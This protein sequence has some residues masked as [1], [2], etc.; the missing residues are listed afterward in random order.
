MGPKA[1]VWVHR[2]ARLRRSSTTASPIDPG[3]LKW[4]ETA[5]LGIGLAVA[6]RVGLGLVMGAAWIAVRS[7]I[8]AEQLPDLSIYGRLPMPGSPIG[9]SLLGV[10]PR[11]DAVQHLNLALRG[12]ADMG[13]GSTVFFPL[14]ALLT[15]AVAVVAGDTIV[16]GLIVSTIAAA[17]AFTFLILI[18]EHLF[19]RDSGKWAA[20]ALAA[21]PMAVF[22]MAP[23]TES[24]YLAL[25]LGAFLAAYRMRWFAAAGLGALASFTRGPGMAASAAFAVLA[26][27]Q[28][29]SRGRGRR[30]ASVPGVIAAVLAPLVAAGAFLAWRASAGF[31]P[32][33]VVLE[34]YVHTTLVDPLTGAYLALRQWLEIHDIPTTL[35]ILSAAGMVA[36]TTLMILRKRWRRPELLAYMLVN[37]VVLLGR[38]TEG[39][40]S[41]KSLSRY[42]LVLFPAFLVVGDWLATTRRWIR[43]GYVAVSSTLLLILSSLYVFW[44]FIG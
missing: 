24:L 14:Y 39:A 31:A 12:Y 33:P 9:Q 2:M 4:R 28:W 6:L 34:L 1:P 15:R 13:E 11:W 42:V 25:T 7:R 5:A 8:S 43:F 32:L 27:Q 21:Y 17:F 30:S 38:H 18:G 23:F 41:L 19:G 29:S 40:P 20:V 37:L 22:L 10:W 26:W 3:A 36:V 16:A 35:D 44:W